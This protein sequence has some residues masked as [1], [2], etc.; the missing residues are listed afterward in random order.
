M[1]G[2]HDL[3]EKLRKLEEAAAAP[4]LATFKPQYYH[5]V[6]IGNDIPVMM[7]D[8]GVF[9][10]EGTDNT[11]P[12]TGGRLRGAT[13]RTVI[14]RLYGDPN[15]RGIT[16]VGSVDGRYDPATK[17]KTPFPP[18]VTWY[19]DLENTKKAAEQE[20]ASLAQT[21]DF[22][23]NQKDSLTQ[24]D[25][26]MDK[27]RA[28]FA[29]DPLGAN[30]AKLNANNVKVD[31]A[32]EPVPPEAPVAAPVAIAQPV[33]PKGNIEVSPLVDANVAKQILRVKEL[34]GS[35]AKEGIVFKSRIGTALLES[36]NLA[37]NEAPQDDAIRAELEPLFKSLVQQV[38]DKKIIG[39]QAEEITQLRPQVEKWLADHPAVTTVA[40]PE[41]KLAQPTPG[42]TELQEYLNSLGM[43]D[44][45][46]QKLKED[47]VWGHRSQEAKA[48]FD[49]KY[50]TGS[51]ED[52]KYLELLQQVPKNMWNVQIPDAKGQPTAQK[53]NIA[54]K[55]AA[56]GQDGTKV[57]DPAAPGGKEVAPAAPTT[58]TVKKGETLSSIAKNSTPPIALADLIKANPDIDINKLKI[59]QTLNLPAG[60]KAGILP[61]DSAPKEAPAIPKITDVPPMPNLPEPPPPKRETGV[62]GTMTDDPTYQAWLRKNVKDPKADDLYWINGERYQATLRRGRLTWIKDQPFGNAN[63]TAQLRNYTGPDSE[64]DAFAKAQQKIWSDAQRARIQGTV[65]ESTGFANDELNRIISLVHH[66]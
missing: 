55:S 65:K 19:I 48:K 36:F 43:T 31:P 29:K 66:R 57:A 40:K 35:V 17:K 63:K 11:D 64:S 22:I 45:N 44:A 4:T 53:S 25:A 49:A 51:P 26:D 42:V 59:G 41:R 3:L 54:L 10:Y 61:A 34:L 50:P 12:E 38:T 60:T 47:G 30:G 32:A 62:I 58:I 1:N 20:K 5:E 9:W 2:L 39:A 28:N 56:T 46:G 24:T 52:K 8:P 14:R 23:K 21:Q 27:Y 6:N 16:A 13:G 37:L 18:G 15:A 7:T 33:P